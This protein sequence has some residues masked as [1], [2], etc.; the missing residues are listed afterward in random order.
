ML[1]ASFRLCTYARIAI[2]AL[3]VAAPIF[4]LR[5]QTFEVGVA[6]LS[7]QIV[8]ELKKGDNS[9]IAVGL[10]T[11]RDGTCSDLT[12]LLYDEIV[13][14]LF[15]L[16]SQLRIIERAELGQLFGELR[17]QRS[18][19]INAETVQE[20]GN[21][22]GAESLL[23]GSISNFGD[24]MRLNGRVLDTDT[25]QVTSVARSNFS[26]TETFERMIANRSVSKCGFATGPT[27]TDRSQSGATGQ[28]TSREVIVENVVY[29]LSHVGLNES[30]DISKLTLEI[31]NT[32]DNLISFTFQHPNY[33]IMY[34]S[35]VAGSIR[36][37]EYDNNSDFSL[38][39]AN[40]CFDDDAD[41]CDESTFTQV[42]PGSMARVIFDFSSV[43]MKGVEPILVRAHF[44]VREED[45]LQSVA[46]DFRDVFFR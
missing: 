35:D 42:P 43:P 30:E 6:E 46:V 14:S 20:L 12:D 21:V 26:L 29:R 44:L 45:K 27:E 10:F 41:R 8:E 38:F 37:L 1:T 7:R 16:Q 11:H 4:G 34:I 33:E 3:F 5:A 36:V 28:V 25:A 23:I 31:E 32:K 17:L 18:G 2:L 22:T 9:A 40:I 24:A 13:F 15:N 19:A 39:G